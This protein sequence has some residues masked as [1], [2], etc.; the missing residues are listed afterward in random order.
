VQTVLDRGEPVAVVIRRSRPQGEGVRPVGRSADDND[1][2]D[3]V[4]YSGM[5]NFST[6]HKSAVRI[7][8]ISVLVTEISAEMVKEKE[9]RESFQLRDLRRTAETML[10]SLKVSSDVRAQLQSHGLGG[11]QQGTMTA[12]ATRLRRSKR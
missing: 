10:A 7:E 11:I 3:R 4:T 1:P 5:G 12:T 9:A 6:D 8:T 2:I